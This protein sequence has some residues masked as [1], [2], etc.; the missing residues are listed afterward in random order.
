MAARTKATRVIECTVPVTRIASPATAA[1]LGRRKPAVRCS[2]I[3]SNAFRGF[4]QT[5]ID[6]RTIEAG[7]AMAL[8]SLPGCS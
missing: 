1:A 7:Q 2:R 8:K 5:D 6:M 3:G 4:S